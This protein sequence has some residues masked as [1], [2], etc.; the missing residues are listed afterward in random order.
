[1]KEI[2]ILDQLIYFQKNIRDEED[3]YNLYKGLYSTCLINSLENK[4][5][6]EFF[7]L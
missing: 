3:A 4:N 6:E 7:N 1:M 2:N 5:F